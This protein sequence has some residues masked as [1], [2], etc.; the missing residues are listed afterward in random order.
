MCLHQIEQT[1]GTEGSHSVALAPDLPGSHA[2]LGM[3]HGTGR[4]FR[5]HLPFCWIETVVTTAQTTPLSLHTNCYWC[6]VSVEHRAAGQGRQ[7]ACEGQVSGQWP[8]LGPGAQRRP[9]PLCRNFSGQAG[10][11]PPGARVIHTFNRCSEDAYIHSYIY[12]SLQR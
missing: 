10:A 2:G 12:R 7:C 1:L 4:S 11:Q 3:R 8:P 9:P 6:K 5:V